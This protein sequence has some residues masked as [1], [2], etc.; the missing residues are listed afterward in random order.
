MATLRVLTVNLSDIN[1][2]SGVIN[3]AVV[4]VSLER[5]TTF[6]AFILVPTLDYRD[7]SDETGILTFNILP[8]DANT[9]YRVTVVDASGSQVLSAVFSMPDADADLADLL[10][11]SYFPDSFNVDD[12]NS[13]PI[14]FKANGS[15]IGTPVSVRNFNVLSSGLF[16]YD[17][18]NLKVTLD[19]QSIE[20]SITDLTTDDVAP[21]AGRRYVTDVQLDAVEYVAA[22]LDA[23]MTSGARSGAVS[24]MDNV[25]SG[26]DSATV[27]GQGN[28]ASGASSA[29]I[30]GNDNTASAPGSVSVTGKHT[31][32]VSQS[33]GATIGAA[34]ASVGMGCAVEQLLVGDT[35]DATATYL[36]VT[37]SAG[38]SAL[39]S[40]L[41]PHTCLDA[42]D[43]TYYASRH[44]ITVY[45]CAAGSGDDCVGTI[46]SRWKS[47]NGTRSRIGSDT[48]TVEHEAASMAGKLAAI[49]VSDN[50]GRLNIAVTG[51]AATVIR[52]RAVVRSFHSVS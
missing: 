20:D 21:A 11:L 29:T 30:A 28:T 31:G 34:H 36:D 24:G 2:E 22:L 41:V 18:D 37:G 48:V 44:E 40:A 23:N 43:G 46:V 50:S 35:T 9:R 10:S 8:N 51:T 32:R 45:A 6:D 14:Q 47:M 15:S 38:T 39:A 25:A 12:V 52:W 7:S 17:G 33:Y 26:D 5:T 49:A 1:L 42:S 16:A 27:A 3:G 4:Q 19:L 13:T